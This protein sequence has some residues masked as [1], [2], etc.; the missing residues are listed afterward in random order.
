MVNEQKGKKSKLQINPEATKGLLK[1]AKFPPLQWE[2]YTISCSEP[3]ATVWSFLWKV[4]G[5]PH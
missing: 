2:Q 1:P 5:E 4:P 3:E